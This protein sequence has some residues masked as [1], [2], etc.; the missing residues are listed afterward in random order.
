[1][2]DATL[3][4]HRLGAVTGKIY[5]ADGTKVL[6]DLY[7]RFGITQKTQGC[8]LGT[9]TTKVRSMVTAAK[10]KSEDAL[11]GAA[12]IVG[13]LGII[14]CGFYDAFTTHP[15]VEKAFDRWRDGA[16]LREDQRKGF[17][18]EDVEWVEY[19]GKVGTMSGHGTGHLP[20]GRANV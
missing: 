10:R 12:P 2:I 7:D 5:D 18:F 6:L 14:G 16:F 15:S 19:Y 8:A 3:A 13:W 4:Y 17:M 20:I 9:E 11:A 1:M